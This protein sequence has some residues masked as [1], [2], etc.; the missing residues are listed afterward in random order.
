MKIR[1][2]NSVISILTFFIS[3]KKNKAKQKFF[4]FMP[5]DI[6]LKDDAFHGSKALSF[7]EWW[8]FDANLDN[9]YSI[10][11][12]IRI[13]DILRS[14]IFIVFKRIDL[15]KDG[16]LIKSKKK[17]YLKKHFFASKE[18]PHVKIKG[19]NII[20]GEIDKKTG[21]LIYTLNFKIDNITANLSFE[22]KTKGYKGTVGKPITKKGITKQGKWAV[23]LPF[24]TVKGKIKIKDK[25][26]DAKGFGYHDHNWDMRGI[27]ITNHGW[28]W[29]KLYFRDYIIVWSK[30]FKTKTIASELLVVSKKNGRYV[31]VKS[32]DIKLIAN[33]YKK[34]KGRLIPH[35]LNLAVNNKNITINIDMNAMTLHYTK[36]MGFINY[37]RYHMKCKGS[38]YIESKDEKIEDSCICEFLRFG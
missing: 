1:F 24:A 34:V 19:K 17:L 9:G 12:S 8:Y 18:I 27:V 15:Y 4:E 2:I 20:K 6:T 21:K 33:N 13:G 5:K 35:H 25:E 11:L 29:G 26:M 14:S 31:N 36:V 16:K 32:D 10:Q 3:G 30:V 28:F 22:G 37:F 38:V 7:T 23:I